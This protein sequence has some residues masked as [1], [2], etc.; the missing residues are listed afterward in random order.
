MVKSSFSSNSISPEPSFFRPY[1]IPFDHSYSPFFPTTASPTTH[2]TP[3]GQSYQ[4]QQTTMSQQTMMR[5][6]AVMSQ[7]QKQYLQQLVAQAIWDKAVADAAQA[8]M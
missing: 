1:L 4:G 7:E 2:H 3:F 6:Q 5:Q 8:T